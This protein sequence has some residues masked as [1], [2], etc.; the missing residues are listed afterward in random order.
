[1]LV[2]GVRSSWLTERD[3]G[4]LDLV[5]LLQPLHGATLGVE[6]VDQGLAGGDLLGDVHGRCTRSR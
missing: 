3:E 4:V 2:I 5:D 1:M 6:R